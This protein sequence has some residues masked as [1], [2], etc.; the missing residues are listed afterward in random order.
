MQFRYYLEGY[1]F[2]VIRDHNSLRWLYNL[3]NPTRRLALWAI[4]LLEYDF[5]IVH[6]K[7]AMHRVPDALP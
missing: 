3:R 2:T 4:D 6:R 7:G 5:K 1:Q